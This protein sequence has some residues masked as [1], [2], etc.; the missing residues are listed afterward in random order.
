[1]IVRFI[2]HAPTAAVAAGIIIAINP[3]Q[4]TG[5]PNP[6]P[7]ERSFRPLVPIRQNVKPGA[8]GMLTQSVSLTIPAPSIPEPA[9]E[10][11][12]VVPPAPVPSEPSLEEIAA[13][14][15]IVLPPE[16]PSYS[17]ESSSEN[18]GK[19]VP[20]PT[21][22]DSPP[23]TIDGELAP[24]PTKPVQEGPT[25]SRL[26]EE[27]HKLA[28]MGLRYKFGA[29]DVD[30][31]GLDCSSTVQYLLEKI[32]IE[33]CP[34]TSYDQYYWLK[35]KKLLDDVYGSNASKKLFKKL[36]PGDLIFWGGT[37]K[38]GH[39]VSHVMI[40]MGYNADTD[41]HYV[42]GARSKNSE[43]ILGNGVDVFELD[44]ERGR[45]IAHGKIPGLIYD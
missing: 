30:S 24:E 22:A 9:P 23:E 33:G 10:P 3:V 17:E 44:T 18:L 27:A 19:E 5:A 16:P 32:G 29:D 25:L 40:Y 4:V 21:I 36:S 42:F 37:W 26:R 28:N 8:N 1:M 38:S 43:G 39:K 12:R 20:E 34:R 11:S 41:K 14:S 2:Q 6:A 7:K 31:G 35:R 13:A 15:G 45:L